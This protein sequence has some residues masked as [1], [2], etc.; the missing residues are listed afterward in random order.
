MV[1]CVYPVEQQ[2]SG[3]TQPKEHVNNKRHV[4]WL[5]MRKL[6]LLSALS[7]T[8]SLL[9]FFLFVFFFWV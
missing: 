4:S 6:C 7:D 5:V 1:Y 3:Y 2:S 9:I 8:L